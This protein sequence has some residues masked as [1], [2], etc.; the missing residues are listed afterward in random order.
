[1]LALATVSGCA[2]CHRIDPVKESRVIPLALSFK[3]VA[4]HYQDRS[5]SKDRLLE[6]I[7]LGAQGNQKI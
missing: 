2:I 5:S 1:M 4:V 7:L 3:E 6:S